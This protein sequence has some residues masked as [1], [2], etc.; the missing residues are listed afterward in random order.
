[1][2]TMGD[3]VKTAAV[4]AKASTKAMTRSALVGTIPIIEFGLL[5]VFSMAI[6]A[7]PLKLL[8][9]VKGNG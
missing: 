8:R 5:I 7:I 1:M 2:T 6:A 9:R 4:V 3:E